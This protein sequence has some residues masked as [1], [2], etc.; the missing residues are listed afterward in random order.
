MHQ[1]EPG[2]PAREQAKVEADRARNQGLGDEAPLK[3]KVEAKE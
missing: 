3:V 2:E 1:E